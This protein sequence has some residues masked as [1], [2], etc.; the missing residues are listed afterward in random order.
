MTPTHR[1][2]TI[3]VRNESQATTHIAQPCLTLDDEAQR[4]TR[5]ALIDA[6][7]VAA[8]NT[9]ARTL[10]TGAREVP[11]FDPLDGGVQ[12]EVLVLLQSPARD[13]RRPR[14]VSRDNS[15]ATQRNLKRFLANAGIAR[16]RSVLWNTLPWIAKDDAHPRAP[17]RRDLDTGLAALPAVLD[18]LASLR[19]VVLAGRIAQTA[20]T[21]IRMHR[22]RLVI[23]A[24]PHP[25]PLSLCTDPALRLR[26][27]TTLAEVLE[28][29]DA[30]EEAAPQNNASA[31]A[32]ESA[33]AQKT[34]PE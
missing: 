31:S 3:D 17:S 7:H 18:L 34:G 15:G 16:E 25:S 4:T 26:I 33:S 14:F 8:L 10:M 21:V 11:W 9:Y 5:A 22:P 13:A 6:P 30:V 1:A 12:A 20:A 24:M 32:A 27:I 23:L 2:D 19:V 29:I 28:R